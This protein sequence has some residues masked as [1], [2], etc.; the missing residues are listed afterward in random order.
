MQISLWENNN[1]LWV[2][3]K[4]C[5]FKFLFFFHHHI[6]LGTPYFWY[7]TSW[8]FLIFF[9]TDLIPRVPFKKKTWFNWSDLKMSLNAQGDKLRVC[10]ALTRL[11]YPSIPQHARFAHCTTRTGSNLVNYVSQL[12]VQMRLLSVT[13]FHIC[14]SFSFLCLQWHI[15]RHQ[16]DYIWQRSNTHRHT[17]QPITQTQKHIISF[18]F[19]PRSTHFDYTKG[20]RILF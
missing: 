7:L 6:P 17:S 18:I 5:D 12:F 19:M 9:F 13:D 1:V 10:L 16:G 11:A 20:K 4:F 14:F 15:K 8:L 3:A 2:N